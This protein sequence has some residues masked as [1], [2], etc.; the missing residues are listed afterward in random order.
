MK[1]KMFSALAKIY[2]TKIDNIRIKLKSGVY[3]N[4][5]L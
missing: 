2:A 3:N 1:Q 5:F 4:L